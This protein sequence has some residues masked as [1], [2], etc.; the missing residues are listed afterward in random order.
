MFD[1]IVVGARC[2]GAPTAMLLA[3]KGYKVLLVDRAGFPSDIPHG[4][5]IHR[6]GPRLLKRWGLLEKL[7]A[8]GCPAVT[9]ATSNYNDFN[10]TADALSVNGVAWGY[11]PRRSILDQLLVQ[12]AVDAG[13]EFRPHFSVRGLEMESGTVKG[14]R[15]RNKKTGLQ[16]TEHARITVGADGRNSTIARAVGASPYFNFPSLTC[17]YFSYWEGVEN[18]G[19]EMHVKEGNAVFSFPTHDGLLSIFIAWPIDRFREVRS[20]LEDHFSQVLDGISGF[21]ER[22][23]AGRRVDRFYGSADLPNFFRK[24][25]GSGWALVGDA[26]FHKDPF[27]ALGVADAFRDAEL[28]ADAIDDGLAGIAPLETALHRYE[29]QRNQAASDEYA[30][31]LHFAHLR[32]AKPEFLRLRAAL[33]GRQDA[34]NRFFMARVGMIPREAFFNP[35][36]ISRLLESVPA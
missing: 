11:G 36:N 33:R 28:L 1:A 5:F 19:F 21:G 32:G 14:I 2:G 29:H 13:A 9:R 7:V 8:T 23:R 3:R 27:L 30:E 22:V 16:I 25:H 31:N 34:I 10:M 18:S 24:P 17:T 6:G 26:G 4:H 15:G 12:A 20:N 35:Q